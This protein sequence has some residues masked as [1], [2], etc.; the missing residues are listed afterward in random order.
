MT[1][2]QKS[3]RETAAEG[4]L[5]ARPAQ[6]SGTA[7]I[8]LQPLGLDGDRDGLL[9]VP[10]GYQV[11]QPAPL[12]LMLHGAGGNA[13]GGISPFQHL[14]D[15][16]GLILLAVDSRHQTWDVLRGGYGP[17]IT[18]I[19]QAL[20]QTFSR[21]AI[22]STHIA[23]EGFSDGASYALSVGITN[24]DLF[25]HVI[26]FS[27]GFMAPTDQRGKPHLFICHGKWDNVLP[28]DRCS[29]RIVPQVQRAGY[30]VLYREFNGFH[31]VPN[32][33]AKEALDWFIAQH[34]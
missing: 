5:L 30:D 19:D 23:V 26:A 29:R 11:N 6:P 1:R 34:L 7:P 18:F 24:G 21:Y 4:R 17:D 2:Q 3:S 32:A 27:P 13:S 33:I 8:G 20:E 31:T 28:I 9:Y 22:D 15:E 10:K 25:T 16:H 14:A 12:V